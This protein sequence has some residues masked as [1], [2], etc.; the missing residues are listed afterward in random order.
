MSNEV[1]DDDDETVGQIEVT[2]GGVVYTNSTLDCTFPVRVPATA[3][4][5]DRLAGRTGACVEE[6]IRNVVYRSVNHDF[7]KQLCAKLEEH[8]GVAREHK[9]VGEGENKRKEYTE[10]EKKYKARLILSGKVDQETCQLFANEIAKNL[11][12]DPSP[13]KRRGGPSK[14]IRGAAENILQ[15]IAM[16][17]SS[18][19]IVGAKLA[20]KLGLQSFEAVYGEFNEDSLIAALVALDEK[21]KRE[22]VASLL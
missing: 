7:R 10:S 8:T 12:F 9:L 6:A 18:A 20:G 13:S 2:E 4:E 5:F 1:D 21:E 19:A 15:A 14:E 16:N 22:K 17:Q 3:E 11:K